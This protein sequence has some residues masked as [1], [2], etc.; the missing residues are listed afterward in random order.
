MPNINNMNEK[1]VPI[2]GSP[3]NLLN[4]PKGCAFCARCDMAMKS[5]LTEVPKEEVTP[6]GHYASCWLN[7]K[8]RLEEERETARVAAS[9]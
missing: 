8:K 2:G 7:V 4:M 6:D 1:L 3:I 9:S 5:C